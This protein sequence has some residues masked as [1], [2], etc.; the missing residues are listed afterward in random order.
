MSNYVKST[1]FASKDSL[2]LGD[3]AKIVKGTEIDTEFN[4][5]A[6]AIASKADTLSPAF[7]GTPTAPTAAPGTNSTQVATTAFVA[8]VA[9]SLGTISTQDANNVSITGGAISG[10]TDLN[11]ADGGTGASTALAAFNNLKQAATDSYTGVV[12]LAT[13]AEAS[14]GTD[15]TRAV[16]AAGV[17]AHMN[18]NAIGWGQTWQDVTSSRSLGTTYTNSTGRPIFIVVTFR[19]TVNN[20][21][22]TITVDGVRANAAAIN[23]GDQNLTAIVPAGSTYATNTGSLSLSYWSELR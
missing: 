6:V 7:T 15:S 18:A 17:E 8:A 4:N 2:P 10:I 14:A 23:A 13:T 3:P 16:T 12:E 1:N 22:A 5:I 9:N 21:L 20:A 19:A 11:I